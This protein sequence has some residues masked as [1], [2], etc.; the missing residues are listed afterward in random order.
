MNK[1]TANHEK[2]F[3]HT[4]IIVAVFSTILISS[5]GYGVYSTANISGQKNTGVSA[6]KTIDKPQPLER[7]TKQTKAEQPSAP[8]SSNSTN[9]SDQ[10]T[11]VEPPK[12][13]AVPV[14]PKPAPISTPTFSTTIN[15]IGDLTCQSSTLE[16]LKLLSIKAPTHY[17]TVTKYISIIEC[18]SQGSGMFAYESPPRYL[19]GDA[20]RNAGTVWYAGTI[21][22][23]AGHSKLYNDYLITN[24]GQS[25]PNDAWTGEAAERSCLDAQYDVLGKI[26]GAQYQL[27]YIQN[28]INTQYYN[29]PYD[30]RWW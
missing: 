13:P 30:Q 1:I 27:D 20:T 4:L 29:V 14:V 9:T 8:A 2:G 28:V 19:V 17:S 16:A 5:V 26:G 25:V 15:I 7:V 11:V 21:V 10:A 3:S 12:V 24:S 22:H 6:G 23:D 18:A